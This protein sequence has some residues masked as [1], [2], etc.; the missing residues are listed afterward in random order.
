MSAN[1]DLVQV[2]DSESRIRYRSIIK[3]QIP[4]L[5]ENYYL[6]P[7]EQVMVDSI[8]LLAIRVELEQIIGLIP[9]QDWIA[10][11]SIDE[12]INYCIEIKTNE[13]KGKRLFNI[14]KLK[15]R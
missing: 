6:L 15:I 12:I 14:S 13:P 5:E 1:I 4:D 11:N 10:L 8:D 7:F 9:D 2:H 3:Q